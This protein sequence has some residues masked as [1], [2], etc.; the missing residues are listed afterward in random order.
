M[1]TVFCNKCGKK[2]PEDS[3]FC[4]RCGAPVNNSVE[5]PA[6]SDS[7]KAK[8]IKMV[9]A[10]VV[11]VLIIGVI[12][13][14]DIY[15]KQQTKKLLQSCLWEDYYHQIYRTLTFKDEELISNDYYSY[16]NDYYDRIDYPKDSVTRYNYKVISK[17][18][19]RVESYDGDFK[20]DIK[21]EIYYRDGCMFLVPN[22]TITEYD[23]IDSEEYW[24][25]THSKAWS[26]YF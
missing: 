5:I 1:N 21:F 13:G 20:K 17:N 23:V 22:T 15:L 11:F 3:C 26:P 4:S 16:A 12:T 8:I 24:K 10:A 19:I 14:I 18:K 7:V 2:L 9:P 25:E 6:A